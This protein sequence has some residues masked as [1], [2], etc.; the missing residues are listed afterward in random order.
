MTRKYKAVTIASPD[1]RLIPRPNFQLAGRCHCPVDPHRVFT[2]HVKEIQHCVDI[3][4]ASHISRLF[5]VGA[6]GLYVRTKGDP[7]LPYLFCVE[8]VTQRGKCR[9]IL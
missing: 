5:P 8:T 2:T 3:P 9:R 6:G 7:S 4:L 1:P